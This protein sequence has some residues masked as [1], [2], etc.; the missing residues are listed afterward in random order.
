MLTSGVRTHLASNFSLAPRAEDS[1]LW[2][3]TRSLDCRKTKNVHVTNLFFLGGGSCYTSGLFGVLQTL[4]VAH[5]VILVA[6]GY[7]R[8]LQTKFVAL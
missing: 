7:F 5:V 6:N 4:F 3:Q 2:Q 1:A 8:V